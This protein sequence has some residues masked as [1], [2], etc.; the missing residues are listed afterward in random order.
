MHIDGILSHAG[1]QIPHPSTPAADDPE[2]ARSVAESGLVAVIGFTFAGVVTLWSPAAQRLFGWTAAEA[3]GQRVA[4]LVD[5]GLTENDL[6]EFAF[7]GTNS[8][9]IREHEVTTRAGNRIA[10]RTTA[11]LVVGPDGKDEVLAS[12]TAL[13]PAGDGSTPPASR[14]FRPIAERGSDLVL[15]CDRNSIISYAGPSL[16]EVL[17]FRSREVVGLAMSELVHPQDAAL[18]ETEWQAALTDTEPHR[19][20]TLRVQHASGSWRRIELRISNLVADLAV[21]AMVLNLR[22]VTEQHELAERLRAN[23]QLLRSVLSTAVEGIWVVDPAGRTVRANDRVGSLLAVES[24]EVAK[25]SLADILDPAAYEDLWQRI[26]R[27]TGPERFELFVVRRDG[28]RRWLEFIIVP[29]HDGAGQFTGTLLMC[30][31]VTLRKLPGQQVGRSGLH[32]NGQVGQ[33]PNRVAEPLPG[34]SRLSG[35]EYEVVRMLLLG[36]RV[37]VIARNLYVSQSTVRNHLSSVFRKLRVRSQQELIVLLRER[38][39]SG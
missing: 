6:A 33:P 3:L 4:D 24:A 29:L 15:I 27:R 20:L 23:E 16:H 18:L 11:S 26:V 14:P 31:D 39:Q 32:G 21:S 25:G 19:N 5:W 22:D 28:Q 35:R 12:L 37:P 13:D 8:A 17:G 36:D 1:K 9:W 34:L 10:L 7:V 30:I 38:N 2:P